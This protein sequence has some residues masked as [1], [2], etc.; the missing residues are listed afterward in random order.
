[1]VGHYLA[2]PAVGLDWVRT[3]RKNLSPRLKGC[4]GVLRLQGAALV[5]VRHI[6]L[7]VLTDGP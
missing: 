4:K 5:A 6:S 7:C 2:A 1:M 3:H